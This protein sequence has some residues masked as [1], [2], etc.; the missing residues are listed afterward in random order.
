[1]GT[2]VGVPEMATV[3]R[4]PNVGRC[5]HS[6]AHYI[7]TVLAQKIPKEQEKN[8]MVLFLKDEMSQ[9]NF[10]HASGRWTSFERMARNAFSDNGFG[11]GV[12][13]R[14]PRSAYR[15]TEDLFKFR[16]GRYNRNADKFDDEGVERDGVKFQSAYKNLGAY[17]RSLDGPPPPSMVQVCYGGI[18]AASVSNILDIDQATWERLE[19]ILT[20]G[21]N[22]EESHFAERSWASLLARPLP[23]FQLQA[24]QELGHNGKSS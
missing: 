14:G 13:M 3:E 22:I 9:K 18:F 24:L 19:Q 1:M 15:H 7:T 4:L 21:N 20:R 5:D 23:P 16:L 12:A 8:S 10:H 11:C 6:Y 17:Y 2:V